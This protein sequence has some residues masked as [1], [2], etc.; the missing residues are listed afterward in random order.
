MRNTFS[1]SKSGYESN[2]R[3]T[4]EYYKGSDGNYVQ[5]QLDDNSNSYESPYQQQHPEDQKQS[6][7]AAPEQRSPHVYPDHA[8]A[9]PDHAGKDQSSYELLDYSKGSPY[10]S[11]KEANGYEGGRP[12][13][14]YA[15]EVTGHPQKESYS[16]DAGN[17]GGKTEY[18]SGETDLYS[19]SVIE[20]P[21]HYPKPNP[22]R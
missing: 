4:E 6:Y 21:G 22:T 20:T 19:P 8:D 13:F 3:P 7:D 9:Y 10:E 12:P 11:T 15:Y 18:G 1:E 14:H 2:Q 5:K 17:K 16:Q